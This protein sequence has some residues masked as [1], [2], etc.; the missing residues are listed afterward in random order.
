[1]AHRFLAWRNAVAGSEPASTNAIVHAVCWR[2]SVP[3]IER[4]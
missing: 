3:L 1:M 2:H 4:S